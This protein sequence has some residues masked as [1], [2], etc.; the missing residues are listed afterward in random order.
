[1]DSFLDRN[2]TT[3]TQLSYAADDFFGVLASSGNPAAA[4]RATSN[5]IG[6]LVT[7]INPLAGLATTLGLTLGSVLIPRLFDTGKQAKETADEL[8]ATARAVENFLSAVGKNPQADLRNE[9]TGVAG[10]GNLEGALSK[11]NEIQNELRDIS[12]Q[13]QDLFIL[14]KSL[15]QNPGAGTPEQLQ[16][17]IKKLEETK[18]RYEELQTLLRIATERAEELNKEQ[19]K[20]NREQKKEELDEH[21]RKL[22]EARQKQEELR[23][24]LENEFR[25]GQIADPLERELEQIRQQFEKKMQE[26]RDNFDGDIES[27]LLDQAIGARESLIARAIDNATPKAKPLEDREQQ[28]ASFADRGS[29]EAFS[30]IARATSGGTDKTQTEI[31]KSTKAT[32]KATQAIAKAATKGLGQQVQLNVVEL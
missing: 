30:A 29:A 9:A 28:F 7:M 20:E 3:F 13:Y 10:I 8:N 16:E 25:L 32:A 2:K 26:I 19:N 4:L 1:M 6:T 12:Q 15:E 22:E 11:R 18:R 14:R 21:I 27:K 5:N 31:A 24:S 23:M 17:T